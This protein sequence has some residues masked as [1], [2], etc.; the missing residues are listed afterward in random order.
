M[1]DDFRLLLNA[2]AIELPSWLNGV[3][4]SA[5]W[6]SAEDQIYAPLMLPYVNKLMD[7][8][9]LLSKGGGAEA[10]TVASTVRME[11]D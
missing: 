3:A 4:V 7:Q 10:S 11:V 9:R 8:E 2:V 6:M 1:A 5:K